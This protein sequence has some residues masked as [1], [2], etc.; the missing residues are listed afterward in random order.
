ME[1]LL[2]LGT[3]EGNLRAVSASFWAVFVDGVAD[4]AILLVSFKERRL[5]PGGGIDLGLA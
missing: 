3:D 1:I 2:G 4:G 5:A